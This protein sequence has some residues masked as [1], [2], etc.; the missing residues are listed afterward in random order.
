MNS[1]EADY[2]A[3]RS[4][5]GWPGVLLAL[6]A[7]HLAG[8]F[9]MQTEWQAMNKTGGL[10]EPRSR[11]ALLRHVAFYTAAFAPAL[12]WI[13]R[14]TTAR[15]ACVVAGVIAVPHMLVD[16]GRLVELWLREVKRAQH[17]PAALAVAVDQSF[18]VISLLGAALVAVG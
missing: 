16:D 17:P 8:D 11:T 14:R 1:P 4:P 2:D 13:G 6:L 12:V 5:V 9:L 18:H 10:R 3:R 15:R 7:S